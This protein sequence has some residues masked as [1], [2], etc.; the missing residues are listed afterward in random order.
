VVHTHPTTKSELDS[1]RNSPPHALLLLGEHGVG[2]RTVAWNFA[3][4]ITR[5]AYVSELKPDDKGTITIDTIRSL[6]RQTR[7]KQESRR[8]IIIDDAEAM[9][10]P[11][12]NAFLKLLEEPVSGVHF[13]LTSHQPTLLLPTIISRLQRIEV[14]PVPNDLTLT[15]ITAYTTDPKLSAQLRFMAE[16]LPAELNRLFSDQE[17]L[18]QRTEVAEKAKQFIAMNRGE[19]LLFINTI[20]G[21]RTE[22]RLF[23][24]M[25]LR[26][27]KL[28]LGKQQEVRLLDLIDTLISIHDNL[29]GNGHVRT[30]LLRAVV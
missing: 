5:E 12:Q 9:S 29:S 23:V 28:Q 8:V 7:A 27:L 22:A 30:Q 19:K 13:I 24:A 16:G 10:V 4:T 2:L 1:L 17:Y 15:I 3:L 14:R 11:A 25:M 6:Y 18:T 21:S 20:A 26:M